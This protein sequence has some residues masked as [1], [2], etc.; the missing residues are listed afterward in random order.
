M[1]MNFTIRDCGSRYRPERP[2]VTYTAPPIPP[3]SAL[4]LAWEDIRDNGR[5]V[6]TKVAKDRSEVGADELHPDTAHMLAGLRAKLA[7]LLRPDDLKRLDANAAM[8]RGL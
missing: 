3:G 1:T 6:R 4:W 7:R 2:T 8:A 5:F